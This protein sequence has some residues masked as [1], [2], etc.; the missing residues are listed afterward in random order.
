M[1]TSLA[2]MKLL[3]L[4]KYPNNKIQVLCQT[5]YQVIFQK[6]KTFKN[7][8]LDIIS[9]NH[10]HPVEKY[11]EDVQQNCAN[12][13][14][15]DNLAQRYLGNKSEL[16]N[17]L[18][19]KSLIAAVARILE[20]GCD[21]HSILVLYS[22]KQGIGKSSFLKALAKNPAWFNDT[23]PKISVNRDFYSKLHRH[24]LTEIGEIDTKFHNKKEEEIKD[25]ITSTKDS[26]RPA[27]TAQF[28]NCRRRFVLTGTTNNG[29]FLK[30]QTGSRRYWIVPVNGKI[31]ITAL[32]K[33][34]C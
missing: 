21:V 17:L 11:L 10:Y 6:L 24:W 34:R 26:F 1:L 12:P 5:E 23:V 3:S 4:E 18:V 15:I 16:S 7:C 2:N 8:L 33:G 30:D 22:P 28:L 31:D 14:N 27:Y 29:N 25:F 13:A 19:K 32:K 9:N 20:P